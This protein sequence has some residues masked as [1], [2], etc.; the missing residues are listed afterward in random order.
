MVEDV[1]GVVA[2]NFDVYHPGYVKMFAECASNCDR[3][4][5]LLHDDPTLERPDKCKPILSVSERR[6]MLMSIKGIHDV[7]VYQT[8]ADLYDLLCE[9][10]PGIRFLGDDYIDKA[11]TGSDLDIPIHYLNRSHG[12]STTKFKNLIY[13][14]IKT[15]K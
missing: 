15:Q 7:L 9:L 13:E 6:A 10:D 5:V 11:F 2:G 1:I 12:W 8:E 14:S 4:L 3:L